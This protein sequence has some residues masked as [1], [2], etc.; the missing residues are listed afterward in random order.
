MIR[1]TVVWRDDVQN[2]LAL[3]NGKGGWSLPMELNDSADYLLSTRK[4]AMAA[5]RCYVAL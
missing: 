4:N 1:Y 2:D 5:G 3:G